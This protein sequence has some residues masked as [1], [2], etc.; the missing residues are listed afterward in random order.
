MNESLSLLMPAL[1][2]ALLHFLWQGVVLGLF[3][4]LALA[5]LRNARPQARY[6]VACVALLACVAWPAI[7]LLQKL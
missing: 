4:A 1:A 7:T 6:A 3:A 5:L 2:G